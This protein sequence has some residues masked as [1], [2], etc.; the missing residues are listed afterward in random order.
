MILVKQALNLRV[1]ATHIKQRGASAASWTA[2][3]VGLTLS[4]ATAQLVPCVAH[5]AG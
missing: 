3:D 1:W 4:G 5:N 2:Q